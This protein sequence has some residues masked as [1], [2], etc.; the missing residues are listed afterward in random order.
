MKE[1]LSSFTPDQKR[2]ALY[3][4]IGLIAV[5]VIIFFIYGFQKVQFGDEYNT[6]YYEKQRDKAIVYVAEQIN[7]QRIAYR[8]YAEQYDREV[9]DVGKELFETA[10]TSL[11]QV[12]VAYQVD[13]PSISSDE[14][15]K[16]TGLLAPD[17]CAELLTASDALSSDLYVAMKD[18]LGWSDVQASLATTKT[19]IDDTLIPA[20]DTCTTE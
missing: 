20:L 6:R 9:F 10:Y 8:S 1:F 15:M 14:V 11:E 18:A 19:A 7:I 4:S 17:V 13:I 16:D 3:G 5:G 2:F 12:A